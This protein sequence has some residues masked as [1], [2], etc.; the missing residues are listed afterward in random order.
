M[1]GHL[2]TFGGA[3]PDL[4]LSVESLFGTGAPTHTANTGLSSSLLDLSDLDFLGL[5]KTS[6]G[7][8]AG[9]GGSAASASSSAS[10]GTTS[11]AAPLPASVTRSIA[12]ALPADANLDDLRAQVHHQLAEAPTGAP[13]PTPSTKSHIPAPATSF[14]YYNSADQIRIQ[15]GEP[16]LVHTDRR[17]HLQVMLAGGVLLV[18][19]T[20]FANFLMTFVG[21]RVRGGGGGGGEK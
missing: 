7:C 1:P 2:S 18:V 9:G 15:Y 20:G 3:L 16:V 11:F 4:P 19:V 6:P 12:A 10:S 5:G 21:S 17:K 13:A 8:V 14:V